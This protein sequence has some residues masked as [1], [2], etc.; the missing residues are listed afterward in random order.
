MS[1]PELQH[2]DEPLW[3]VKQ[4]AAFLHC[5]PSM[6]RKMARKHPALRPLRIGV[7]CR[8]NPEK[9]RAFT[10]GELVIVK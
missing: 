7:L 5:S 10:R 6:V 4:V 2:Q 8:W 9:V 1:A 3:D